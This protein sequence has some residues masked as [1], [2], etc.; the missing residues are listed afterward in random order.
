MNSTPNR[1]DPSRPCLVLAPPLEYPANGGN[2]AIER[3]WAEFSRYVPFV[4]VVG[5]CTVTRYRNGRLDRQTAF[6]NRHISKPNA[7][8]RAIARNSHYLLEKFVTPEFRHVA[9]EYLGN[10]EYNLVVF[11]FIWTAILIEDTPSMPGRFYCVETHNDEFKWF[12]NL[13]NSYR[14]PVAKWAAVQSK[15]WLRL[16]LARHSDKRFVYFH[17]SRADYE[18]YLKVIP[19]HT[20][21]VTRVGSDLPDGHF[22][23][24][25]V[26]A[27]IRLIF[28]GSLGV[29]MNLDGLRIF[30]EEFYPDLRA[31]FGENVEVLVV[32]SNPSGDVKALCEEM[33]WTIYADVSQSKL[34]ELYK[35]A[36]FSLLPFHY[37]VGRKL[38]ILE[39]LGLGVP[40]LATTAMAEQV[41]ELLHPCLLSDDPQE[42]VRRV[43]EVQHDGIHPER[44]AALVKYARRYSWTAIADQ[45]Y[46]DL[47]ELS[48]SAA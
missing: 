32:G 39:T 31:G 46:K 23:W 26:G 47:R 11:S 40:F 2:V 10:P 44:R 41:D 6:A 3:R 16:F 38:K 4:D 25:P 20:G 15:R 30:R 42:W 33:N 37:V 7:A 27:K 21:Y 13:G 17:V 35:S 48:V 9:R 12:D 36:T 19:R 22:D 1:F 8:L 29:K 43:R 5:K 18:G 24:P 45:M 14:N 28:V 34:F